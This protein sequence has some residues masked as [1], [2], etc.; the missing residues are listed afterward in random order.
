MTSPPVIAA[1][2]P[3][4]NDQ[5]PRGAANAVSVGVVIAAGPP[6]GNDQPPRGAANAVS[7]GVV[8]TVLILGVGNIILSDEAVGVRAVEALA[9]AYDLPPGVRALDGGTSGMEMLDDIADVDLLIMV[10][11]LN[12]DQPQGTLL[13]LA[14]DEV[15]V[16]FR[17][18]LSPHQ[19]GLPD[20][21]ASLEFA[22][23]SP[24]DMVIIG[25]EASNFELGLEMSPAIAACVPQLVDKV[26][27]EL[28]AR[29][30]LLSK[31]PK[32]A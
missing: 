29:G 7:V 8:T 26:V 27:G 2:P 19:I 13:R 23:R 22:G 16:F 28:A 11:A 24:K 14:G 12:T 10:D 5:P 32:A 20:V 25:V 9:A 3:Q 6:Q 30:I 31:K 21:L 17:Q 18:K 15:P 1:G 4:G